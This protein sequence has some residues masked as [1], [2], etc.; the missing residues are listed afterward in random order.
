MILHFLFV[1]GDKE[2]WLQDF[3]GEYREKLSR[4]YRLEVTR[5]KPTKEERANAD[6]KR[7]AETDVILGK[8]KPT[9]WVVLFDER[10]DA[11]T[12]IKFAKAMEGWLSRGKSRIVF[13]V[14]GAFGFD[15]PLRLRADVMVSLSAMILN[16]HLAQ[17]VV[18]EQVYRA[19]SIQ[20]NL[21][22][23]NG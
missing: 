20:K 14:G 5:L 19:I 21:P 10:G 18:M 7:R 22:Y 3:D 13:V 4:H 6:Q 8:I 12:S 11:M 15:E 16:H 2:A 1:G 9:D 23:H 17:A